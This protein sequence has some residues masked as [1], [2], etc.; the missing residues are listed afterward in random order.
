MATLFQDTSWMNKKVQKYHDIYRH[1]L[2]VLKQWMPQI[3]WIQNSGHLLETES[4]E[5][6]VWQLTERIMEK[7]LSSISQPISASHVRK[8]SYPGRSKGRHEVVRG[9]ISISEKGKGPVLESLG[10]DKTMERKNLELWKVCAQVLFQSSASFKTGHSYIS[11][12]YSVRK[13][14][15][16]MHCLPLGRKRYEEQAAQRAV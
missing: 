1:M 10:N 11:Q 7:I 3:M 15:G 14:K 16:W 5:N 12:R 13:R 8:S 6:L 9:Y 2:W 4:P